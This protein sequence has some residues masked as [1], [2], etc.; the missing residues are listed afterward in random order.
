MA[1]KKKID[2]YLPQTDPKILKKISKSSLMMYK[3]IVYYHQRVYTVDIHECL[4]IGEIG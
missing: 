3:K 4:N 1:K 2:W